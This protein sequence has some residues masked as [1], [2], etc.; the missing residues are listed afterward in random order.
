MVDIFVPRE[1]LEELT[2]DSSFQ[3]ACHS[4]LDCFNQCCRNPTIILKPYDILRLRRQLGLSSTEFLDRYTI[5]LVEDKSRL[6]LT[7]VDIAGDEGPGCPFLTAAGC[8]VY[9]ARPGACRLFPVIQGSNLGSNGLEDVYFCKHLDF[10]QGFR[11]GRELNLAQWRADQ[12]LDLYED[13]NRGWLEIILKRGTRPPGAE[14]PRATALFSLVAYD[15]DRFRRFAFST[16]LLKTL[17]IPPDVAAVLQESDEELLRFGYNY[18]KLV[19]LL[20][21]P[22]RLKQAMKTLTPPS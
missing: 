16:P 11:E 20:D 3:F 14:D 7:L 17:A 8:G 6:P 13:L 4:G 21:D 1:E 18:L 5:Q 19:L 10:C 9:A 2:P 15:L 12:G 22:V